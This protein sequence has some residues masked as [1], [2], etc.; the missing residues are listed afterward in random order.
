MKIHLPA[1][2]TVLFTFALVAYA[3]EPNVP[4]G[5]PAPAGPGTAASAPAEPASAATPGQ[6]PVA[7][8]PVQG[9]VSSTTPEAAKGSPAAPATDAAATAKLAHTLGYSPRSH[10][11]KTVYCRTEAQL[12][13]R[14]PTTT[15]IT[16]DQVTAAAERTRGNQDTVEAVQRNS[17]H[18]PGGDFR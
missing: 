7:T 3:A 12:G 15:C 17:T 11:G 5:T 13:T 2:S 1:T 18:E 16:A 14:F 8:T 4:A 6:K 9:S 10:N